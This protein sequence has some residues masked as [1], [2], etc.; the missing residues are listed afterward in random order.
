MG[1][2]VLLGF[3]GPGSPQLR[4]SKAAAFEDCLEVHGQLLGF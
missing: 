2:E 1:C 3:M 4:V